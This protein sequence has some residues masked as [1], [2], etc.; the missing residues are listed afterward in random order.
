MKEL[1]VLQCSEFPKQKIFCH[2]KA[3]HEIQK[4]PIRLFKIVFTNEHPS[5]KTPPF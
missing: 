3:E 1:M 5:Q 2:N 4:S